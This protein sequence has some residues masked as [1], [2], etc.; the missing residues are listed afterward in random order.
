VGPFE[1]NADTHLYGDQH[2]NAYGDTNLH[3]NMD[4]DDHEHADSDA[5]RYA[6]EYTDRCRVASLPAAGAEGLYSLKAIRP[7]LE[8][9]G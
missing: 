6:H 3:V 4:A 2:A 7:E 9:P 1:A 5:I 8:A